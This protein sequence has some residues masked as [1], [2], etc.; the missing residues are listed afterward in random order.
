MAYYKNFDAQHEAVSGKF[1]LMVGQLNLEDAQ[2]DVKLQ[3]QKIERRKKL[4]KSREVHS[5]CSERSSHDSAEHHK[6][7]KSDESVVSDDV[8]KVYGVDE[9]VAP[10]KRNDVQGV[11]NTND[12][13][14]DI[15]K[16]ENRDS[17]DSIQ[18]SDSRFK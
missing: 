15:T 6:G 1:V 7:D 2:Q 11:Y 12:G 3:Q 10:G 16:I 17:L 4:I 13:L 8:Q 14:V 5:S 9:D 18:Q